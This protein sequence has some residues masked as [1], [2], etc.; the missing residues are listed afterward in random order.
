[1]RTAR[2][3]LCISLAA[4]GLVF[5][6]LALSAQ[7]AVAET[8]PTTQDLKTEIINVSHDAQVLHTVIL[9]EEQVIAEGVNLVPQA[10]PL[11][12]H[13]VQPDNEILRL[14]HLVTHDAFVVQTGG[15]VGI[16]TTDVRRLI[17]NI[18][19][20]QVAVNAAMPPLV[21][22]FYLPGSLARAVTIARQKRRFA[23]AVILYD[24]KHAATT[25]IRLMKKALGMR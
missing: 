8:A 4:G 17:G 1:M 5:G 11:A 7:S 22:A 13:V 15:N 12:L 16:A 3:A 6:C 19:H 21:S 10:E 25:T 18:S 2:L 23:P 14:A 20:D 9:S 24:L